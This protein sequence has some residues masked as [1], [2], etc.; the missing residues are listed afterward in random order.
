MAGNLPQELA[1]T[2]EVHRS[3][4][5]PLNLRTDIQYSNEADRKA[6]VTL[7][8]G[9]VDGKYRAEMNVTHPATQ[10]D[11]RHVFVYQQTDSR[12]QLIHTFSHKR[13]GLEALVLEHLGSIDMEEKRLY[14]SASSPNLTLR[15]Q[16]HLT[17]RTPRQ[18]VV[19]YETQV[20]DAVS[21]FTEL[22]V[23]RDRPFAH[24]AAQYDPENMKV[25]PQQMN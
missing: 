23:D 11:M 1:F 25:L 12:V 20:D 6:V 8:A 7:V 3:E 24:F 4:S 19:G 18:F 21:M 9:V 10:L 15:H 14:F 17:Q 5:E 13:A 2:T 22:N 16:G